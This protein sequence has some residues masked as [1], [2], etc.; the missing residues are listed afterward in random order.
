MTPEPRPALVSMRTTSGFTLLMTSTICAWTLNASVASL[1]DGVAMGVGVA[2]G[3]DDGDDDGAIVAAA[4]DA[5]DCGLPDWNA[6]RAPTLDEPDDPQATA[7]SAIR[8]ANMTGATTRCV[9]RRRGTDTR[10]TSWAPPSCRWAASR[11]PMIRQPT[12][13]GLKI[14]RRRRGSSSRPW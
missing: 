10:Y 13:M 1:P 11:C 12:E 2:D 5:D 8:M 7:T 14:P 3:S 6:T 9:V 4:S